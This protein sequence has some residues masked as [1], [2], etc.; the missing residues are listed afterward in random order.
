MKDTLHD[1]QCTAK[2]TGAGERSVELG[3]L[4]LRRAC[5]FNSRV[6]LVRGDH[7][8]G[9]GLVVFEILVVARLDIFDQSVLG[10]KSVDLAIA[11][12]VVDVGDFVNP[13]GGPGLSL[14]CRLKIA[15][16][17]RPQILG[18]ADVDHHPGGVL[19]QVNAGGL[20]EIPDFLG[21]SPIAYIPRKRVFGGL[22]VEWFFFGH[23]PSYWWVLGGLPDWTVHFAPCARPLR[24]LL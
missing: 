10:Q 24:D 23:Y 7:Q 21:C 19:H 22:R 5:H 16:G 13:L 12:H 14:G 17:P 3:S 11:F 6:V 8:V 4:G 1:L 20:W 9:K 2:L 15:P 18:L